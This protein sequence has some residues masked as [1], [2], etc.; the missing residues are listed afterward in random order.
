MIVALGLAVAFTAPAVAYQRDQVVNDG[1]YLIKKIAV[2]Y[3][4]DQVVNGRDYLINTIAFEASGETEIG[5]VAVA[6]AV[7]NRKNSGRW[8]DTIEGVVTSPG[9]FEPWMTQREAI[10]CLSPDDPRYKGAA[11]IADAILSGQMP[12]PTAGATHFLNPIIVRA[13]R[14][15]SLP[16]WASGEGRP[17]GRHVFYSRDHSQPSVTSPDVRPSVRDTTQPSSALGRCARMAVA[18]L[19]GS[20]LGLVRLGTPFNL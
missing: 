13:R 12:D 4:R 8:G 14:G 9:Q 20:P 2:A 11:R 3:Q 10:E 7:L 5:K 19:S 15:G 18:S 16:S 6:Y 17:I 1:D